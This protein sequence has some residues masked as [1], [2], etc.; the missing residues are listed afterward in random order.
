MK[1]YILFTLSL[2]ISLLQADELSWVDEQIK[3]ISPKRVGIDEKSISK[4]KSPFIYLAKNRVI[5]KST[6]VKRSTP[7]KYYHA[8]KRVYKNRTKQRHKRLILDAIMNNSALINSH[9]YKLGDSINGYKISTI[10][11]N[12][13]LLTKGNKKIELSTASKIQNLNFNR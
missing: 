7:K 12:S 10:E 3:A 4:V 13:I 11:S 2:F 9:W 6:K 5:K 1:Y 8:K